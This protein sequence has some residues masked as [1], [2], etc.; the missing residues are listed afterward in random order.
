LH[1]RKDVFPSWYVQLA[2]EPVRDR[3]WSGL[4]TS[5]KASMLLCV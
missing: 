5:P 3:H 1:L 4:G 2:H